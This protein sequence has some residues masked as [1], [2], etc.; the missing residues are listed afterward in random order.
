MHRHGGDAELL[1]GAQNSERDLAAVG[2]EDLIEHDLAA[3]LGFPGRGA[4]HRNSGDPE[5]PQRMNSQI[6]NIRFACGA[7]Q[8]RGP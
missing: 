3:I 7:P 2:D 5:F 4:A 6:G 8:I 1:A